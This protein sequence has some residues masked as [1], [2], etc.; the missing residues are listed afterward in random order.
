[1]PTV[2]EHIA[3]REQRNAERRVAVEQENAQHRAL[4]MEDRIHAL[5]AQNAG[6]VSRVEAMGDVIARQVMAQQVAPSVVNQVG[7]AIPVPSIPV[8]RVPTV[9]V[10][11][12]INF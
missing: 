3:A 10:R 9:S 8:G 7:T 12:L 11:K 4:E 6:L 5:E 2:G 1:M